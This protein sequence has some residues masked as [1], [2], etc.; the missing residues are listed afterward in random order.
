MGHQLILQRTLSVVTM[1]DVHAQFDHLRRV[2]VIDD[3]TIYLSLDILMSHS[4]NVVD[5]LNLPSAS[6]ALSAF[7]RK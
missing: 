6:S 3:V 1:S 4:F 7:G 2:R 5:L